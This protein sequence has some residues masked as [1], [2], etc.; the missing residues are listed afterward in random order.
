M[1]ISMTCNFWAIEK[2][3]VTQAR[4]VGYVGKKLFY[5]LSGAGLQCTHVLTIGGAVS[6]ENAR[7]H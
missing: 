6:S 7:V 1:S 4:K 5:M 3:K 2:S